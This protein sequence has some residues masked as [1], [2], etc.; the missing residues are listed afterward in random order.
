MG[1]L[2]FTIAIAN[3]L[4]DY[5]LSKFFDVAKS[6]K[7]KDNGEKKNKDKVRGKSKRK[8][9]RAMARTRT[10]GKA[11][12]VT[13]AVSLTMVLIGLEIVPRKKNSVLLWL[14]KVRKRN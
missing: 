1:D 3:E 12:L 10:V 13:Q 2:P 9:V 4:V 6:N 11:S 5:K 8:A 14:R 7:P